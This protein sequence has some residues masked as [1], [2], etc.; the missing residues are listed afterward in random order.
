MNNN[1]TDLGRT[2]SDEL[3]YNGPILVACI[4]R[5]IH[6][7]DGFPS[8]TLRNIAYFCPTCGEVWGRRTWTV[9]PI[10]CWHSVNR[11]CSRHGGGYFLDDG[12]GDS[13]RDF[14]PNSHNLREFLTQEIL[15]WDVKKD[16]DFFDRKQRANFRQ[17]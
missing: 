6:F 8:V 1:L 5:V 10:D 16:Y 15:L 9:A 11:F 13:L 17:S 4:R 14:D 3:F 2:Y 12:I 7:C